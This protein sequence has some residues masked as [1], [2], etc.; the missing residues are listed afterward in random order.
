MAP[1]LFAGLAR[2]LGNGLALLVLRRRW[3]PQF[4]VGFDQ[5]AALLLVNLAVWALLDFVHAP[6]HVPL[7]L[8][9]L[10]GWASYLLL[11]LFACALLA[12]PKANIALSPCRNRISVR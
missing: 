6:R 12:K 3:P 2:N 9:G 10:F 1:G 7:S 5:V 8:D 11:G 4:A